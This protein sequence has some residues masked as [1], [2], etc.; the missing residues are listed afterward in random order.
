[1]TGWSLDLTVSVQKVGN[2][3]AVSVVTDKLHIYYGSSESGNGTVGSLKLNYEGG[4]NII[5][6]N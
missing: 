1:M 2:K 5:S 6:K 3:Y 4:I